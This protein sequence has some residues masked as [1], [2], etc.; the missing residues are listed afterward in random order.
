MRNFLCI[1]AML[2]L[3]SFLTMAS[4]PPAWAQPEPNK[5]VAGKINCVAKEAA[6]FIKC[7]AKAQKSGTAVSEGCLSTA[8]E[9]FLGAP[10]VAGCFEKLE[11][12]QNAEKPSSLCR[13]EDDAVLMDAL[14]SALAEA[15]AC[16]RDPL[17]CGG[18]C[19]HSP[20]IEGTPLDHCS[21]CVDTIC[22]QPYLADCCTTGWDAACVMGASELC[23]VDCDVAA[24]PGPNKCSAGK[25][26]CL[27]KRIRGLLKCYKTAQARGVAVDEACLQK[28]E[29]EF[30]GGSDPSKGCFA[31]LE[32]KQHPEKPASV[33]AVDSNDAVAFSQYAAE[34]LSCD[35]GSDSCPCCNDRCVNAVDDAP[36]DTV[37]DRS[38]F[39]VCGDTC[40]AKTHF[41]AQC[42][43]CTGCQYGQICVQGECKCEVG[44]P[45][46][47]EIAPVP[48]CINVSAASGMPSCTFLK[49]PSSVNEPVGAAGPGTH[50]TWIDHFLEI[51]TYENQPVLI[52]FNSK[53][54]VPVLGDDYTPM[55]FSCDADNGTLRAQDDEL[56]RD[57]FDA[58]GNVTNLSGLLAETPVA[59]A[60]KSFVDGPVYRG[61]PPLDPFVNLDLKGY[62]LLFTPDPGETGRNYQT[63]SLLIDDSSSRTAADGFLPYHVYWFTIHV[64]PGPPPVPGIL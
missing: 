51:E 20:C 23:N 57:H 36:I 61:L 40:K 58:D 35:L 7:H 28:V 2:P 31:K 25:S 24:A 46:C 17:S 14:A 30:D 16:G 49:N 29:E 11:S 26:L 10:D 22:D 44:E 13:T 37:V 62:Y 45:R 50:G 38:V 19:A 27:A 3:A 12:K 43:T 9:K 55:V 64:N 39:M 52:Y 5:C 4:A 54:L 63:F 18:S 33:C 34:K 60:C 6:A 53:E 47:R 15:T 42:G 32:G 41:S 1:R 56:Q 21:P 48:H 8:R 59:L